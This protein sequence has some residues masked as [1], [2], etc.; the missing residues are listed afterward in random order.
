M[1]RD[2]TIC[3]TLSGTSPR[4]LIVFHAPE[5]QIPENDIDQD[6]PEYRGAEVG[7]ERLLGEL[8]D[9]ARTTGKAGGNRGADDDANED[10]ADDNLLG[11][12]P[13]G[14]HLLAQV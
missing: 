10:N 2:Y 9:D 7:D 1:E 11:N 3:S 6:S 14:A 4:R 13:Q 12:P 8:G 5:Q